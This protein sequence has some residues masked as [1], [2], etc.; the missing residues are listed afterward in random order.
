MGRV[1][2]LTA[3]QDRTG[4]DSR[5]LARMTAG[6]GRGYAVIVACV[7]LSFAVILVASTGIQS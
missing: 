1:S 5:L 7:F 4:L 3:G 2:R 6:E